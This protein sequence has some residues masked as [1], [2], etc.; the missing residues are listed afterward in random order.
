M[1]AVSLLVAV[2]AGLFA[3]VGASA[4]ARRAG[5]DP[6][7]VVAHVLI[8]P[9]QDS[10]LCITAIGVSNTSSTVLSACNLDISQ[11]WDVN[12]LSGNVVQFQNVANNQCLTPLT[13]PPTNGMVITTEP[14]LN[15]ANG[16]PFSG[17]QFDSSQAITQ[18]KLPLVVT[19]LNSQVG[20][21]KDTGFC[22]DQAGSSVVVNA[23]NGGL[24]Q[25]WVMAVV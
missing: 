20:T 14:C 10:A 19:A 6:D 21:F 22:L 15:P 7:A 12:P 16:V 13:A 25:S 8:Q 4:V 23:C 24:S 5:P 11:I 9:L 3:A 17:T 2:A 18:S 1:K